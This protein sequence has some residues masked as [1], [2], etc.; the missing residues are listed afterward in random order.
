M[1]FTNKYTLLFFACLFPAFAFANNRINAQ[2][3]DTTATLII[4]DPLQSNMVVQQDKPFKVWG[5]APTGKTVTIKASWLA[6][7]VTV[8]ADNANRFLGIITVPAVKKSDY[9]KQTI[10]ITCG[11]DKAILNNL[12]IGDVWFCSGQS[13]MQF[14]MSGLED[15]DKKIDSVN[16]PA[17]RLLLVKFSWHAVPVDTIPGKWAECSPKSVRDFSAVAYY[18]ADE[19]QKTLDIPVGVIYSGIGGSKTQAYVAQDVLAA[20]SVLNAKYLQPFYK[21]DTY[22]QNRV[23]K[24][25]FG[26]TSYPYLIYNGMIYPF[27]NL[28]I[29]GILWYQGE[30]NREQR[31]EYVRLNY[32][33]INSWRKNFAQGD[34]PFYYVQVA[35]HAYQKL[36]STLNDYAFF[37]EEQEKISQLANTAMVITMDVGNKDNIH[38]KNKKPVGLRLAYTALNR[39]YGMLDVDYRGPH[40]DFT[41]FVKRGAIVYFQ[42]GTTTGG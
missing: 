10:T 38:P 8:T 23:E 35:P 4:A 18:F 24:F 7:A 2:V 32:T 22:K 13:N 39:T 42:P 33:L 27:F 6:G 34:L 3:R 9:T 1:S 37:R 19:L 29:K 26:T 25:D 41:T 40:Y 15:A 14:A 5:H 31:D 30:S 16:N 36:D 12:L 17:I 11:T 28:S 20:D 21:T